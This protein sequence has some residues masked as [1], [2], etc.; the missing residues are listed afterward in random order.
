M[1]AEFNLDHL[2]TYA[3]E[4]V[5]PERL[6]PNPQRRALEKSRQA[7]KAQLGRAHAQQAEQQRDGASPTQQAKSKEAIERLDRECD[8]LTARINDMQKRV[9][10]NSIQDADRIVHHKRE[11]KTITQLIRLVAYR[12]ESCLARIAEPFFVRHNDEVR[13]FLKAVFHLPGDIIPDYERNELR[14]CLYGLA[15][16]RAQQALTALC[17]YLK[18]QHMRYPGTDLRLIYE[19]IQSH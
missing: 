15:N 7:K 3:T 13:A 2:S 10:L 9:P 12:S 8:Q 1:Q 19:A 18:T 17:D 14:V 5:D 4:P 6:V 16:N 11:R